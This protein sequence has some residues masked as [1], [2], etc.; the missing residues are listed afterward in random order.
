[1]NISNYKKVIGH[2]VWRCP[3]GRRG[4]G[5]VPQNLKN[6]PA[7]GASFC[8][9][10]HTFRIRPC[11]EVANRMVSVIIINIAPYGD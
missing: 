9:R 4:L 5:R 10:R 7:P 8:S 2:T 6:R 11:S 3:L 1:M